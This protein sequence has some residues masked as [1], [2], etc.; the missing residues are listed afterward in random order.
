MSNYRILPLVL[1]LL[2][3]TGC[4]KIQALMGG[5][6]APEVTKAAEDLL[7]AGDLPGAI[8]QYAK[9]R[10]EQP[11]SVHAAQGEAY[12]RLLAGDHAGAEKALADAHAK[13]TEKGMDKNVVGEIEVRRALTAL[14]AGKYD[15]VKE[16]GKASELPAGQFL[17]AEICLA[18]AEHD[19]AIKLFKAASADSGVIGE[20]AKAYLTMIEESDSTRSLAELTA[21]WASGQRQVAVQNVE[22]TLKSLPEERPDKNELLLL[23]AGRAVT[24][25]E[26]GVAQGLIDSMGFPPEGQAWRVEATKAMIAIAEGRN[27]EGVQLFTVLASAEA[28]APADGLADAL[29]TA[30]ALAKDAETAT[31]LAGAVESVA[32]AKGLQMAGAGEAAKQVSPSSAAFT[33]YLGSQ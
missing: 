4:D 27:D 24:S 6:D 9:I 16:H 3:S 28:G 32:A 5:S 25:G 21:L 22:D 30:A 2:A 23:W 31:K 20:T 1:A 7:R 17:A 18:D 10:Q 19:E 11:D 12:A 29:A 13:A 26:P 8:E 33:K 15:A 14:R